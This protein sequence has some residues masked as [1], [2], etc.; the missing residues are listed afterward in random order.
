MRSDRRFALGATVLAL[1]PAAGACSSGGG[2]TNTPTGTPS[3]PA[4]QR[5]T[6]TIGVS[7]AFAENQLVAEMYAE[8]LEKAGYTIKR[9]LDLGTRPVSDP[10]LINGQIDMKPEYL[11]FELPELD[12]NADNTGTAEEVFPRLQAA[13]NAK[14]LT[15]LNFSPADSTNVFVVKP[16]TA[17]KYSLTNMSSVTPVASQLTL[18]AP[19]DC[20]GSA[21]CEVGLKDIYGITFKS[22]KSLDVGG[23][24][25]VA[26]IDSGAVDVGELFSLDPTITQ[27]GYTVLEDDKHL[28]GAGNFVPLIRTE[29]L[30]DEIARLL[31]AV[32]AKLTT[33]GML[34]LVGKVQV[35]HQDVAD[36]AKEFLQSQGLL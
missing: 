17:T 36:V 25:T 16:E 3:S 24:Q 32:Q 29:K 4:V 22:I 7:G 23:P 33:D 20:A 35:E 11:A 6:L 19:P 27:K 5:G 1:A 31:N 13:A 30:N 15:A 2:G 26:A 34:D 10:A 9:Q 18:G 12:P 21:T 14:G 28:Q 8:V